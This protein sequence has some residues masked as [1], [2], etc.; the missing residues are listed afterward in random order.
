MKRWS[1]D[2]LATLEE[3][4]A[5]T[6]N[7]ELAR[8]LG[9]S[10]QAVAVQAHK[11]GLHKSVEFLA[12]CGFQKGYT[13]FNKGR[14]MEEWLSPEV[15]ALIKANQARTATRNRAAAKPDGAISR[16][17]NGDYIK[18]A[19]R[20][21]KLSHHI[22]ETHNGPIPEGCAVFHR[23]GD[24]LNVAPENLYVDRK[25]D[26]SVLVIRRTPEERSAIAKKMWATRRAR[27]AAKY[28]DL[29]RVLAEIRKSENNIHYQPKI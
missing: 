22:W 27:T 9:R 1:I 12:A 5:N 11:M 17:Y 16:R 6:G 24:H 3:R 23:D 28:A 7:D 25:N 19:G 8:L 14:R 2:D 4:Y 15:H 21:I 26:V 13:P 29:D 10:M 18:V 20:W